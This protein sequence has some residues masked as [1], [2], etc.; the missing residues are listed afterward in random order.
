M[1]LVGVLLLLSAPELVIEIDLISM[2]LQVQ[3]V[4]TLNRKIAGEHTLGVI[5][6]SKNSLSIYFARQ[7]I[8]LIYYC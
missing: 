6:L 7:I 5:D 4:K 1:F 8:T 3:L 2:Q